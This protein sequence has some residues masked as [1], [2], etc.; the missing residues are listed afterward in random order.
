M[1]V[2]QQQPNPYAPPTANVADVGDDH[3]EMR[4]ASR[5]TRF[6]AYLLDGFIS[7]LFCLPAFII[8]GADI[9]AAVVSRNPQAVVQLFSGKF[10]IVLMLGMTV[11]AVI[12]I[13]LVHRNGQTIGKKLLSIKVV[14]KDG[15]RASL[16]RIFWLRNVVNTLP[17]LVPVIGGFYFF[18]DSLFIFGEA[19]QCVH[20]KIAGTIV[21]RA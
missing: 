18:I 14:R 17:S 4:I 7:F 15:S 8:S 1:S 19:H 16:G 12:T 9:V 11:W 5:G 20:D 13:I 3:G 21:V 10:L 2:Q 6:G